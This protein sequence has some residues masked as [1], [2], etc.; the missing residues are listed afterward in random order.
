M[1]CGLEKDEGLARTEVGGGGRV[2]GLQGPG[3][4]N[5]EI[6]RGGGR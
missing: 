3:S 2:E 6:P 5:V 4:E 1:K